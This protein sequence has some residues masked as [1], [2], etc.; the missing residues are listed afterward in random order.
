MQILPSTAKWVAQQTDK[1]DYALSKPEDNINIGTWYLAHNHQR[2]DHNSLLAIASY[3]AGTGNVSQWVKKYSLKD[4]D[5]F[6]EQIPFPETKDYVEGVFSN[7]WNYLRLYNP[8]VREK[9]GSKK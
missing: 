1:S 8:E 2:H 3:N 4:P 9:V 7:Y 6:V 5:V